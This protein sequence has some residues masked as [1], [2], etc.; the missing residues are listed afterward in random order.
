VGAYAYAVLPDGMLH[1]E[2]MNKRQL[3]HIKAKSRARSGPWQ[4]DLEEMYRKTPVKR[5]FKY[6][7]IPDA[8]EYAVQV[9]NLTETGRP[10]DDIPLLE[11]SPEALN[12][13]QTDKLKEKIKRGRPPKAPEA[14][15]NGT[16]LAPGPTTGKEKEQ[17]VEGSTVGPR[18]I[19]DD[20]SGII[21]ELIASGRLNESDIL[22]KYDV[23]DIDELHYE[24]A[25]Q[26]ID[27]ANS[28]AP[29]YRLGGGV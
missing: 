5:L 4:T 18:G 3:D 17:A 16:D 13:P 26:I 25:N 9:D 22:A 2:Y 11:K 28:C 10:R 21:R 7:P 29:P 15:E 6:L 23:S 20:Q 1:V 8:L 14:P 24:A 12:T 27:E 19:T